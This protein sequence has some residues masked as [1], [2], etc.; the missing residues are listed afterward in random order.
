MRRFEGAVALVMGGTSG[1]GAATADRLTA[2]GA[3]VVVAGRRTGTDAT[4]RAQVDELLAGIERDH[5]RLDVLVNAIGWVAV[6]P[7][8]SMSARNWETTLTT[9]LTAVFH[10]CQAALPLLRRSAT[11]ERQAA[12]VNVASVNGL[13]GDRGMVAYGAA[14]AGVISLTRSLALE[15]ISHGVRVNSVSPGAID[16]PMTESTAGVP[17]RA[18]AYRRAIPAGRFGRPEEIAAAIAFVASPDASFMVGAD[19][20]VDGGVTSASGHPDLFTMF[21]LGDHR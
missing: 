9:N 17:E 5:G 1:I 2:E 20:V 3:E 4:D 12:I 19:L 10:T 21:D 8:E 7:F 6:R 16:T 15:E 11:A 18:E 14:K 13:A